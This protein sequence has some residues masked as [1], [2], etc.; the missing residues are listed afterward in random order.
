MHNLA[1]VGKPGQSQGDIPEIAS[2]F[3]NLLDLLM[4]HQQKH[5]YIL[6]QV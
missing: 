5:F 3:G 6:L 2:I 4:D 1:L